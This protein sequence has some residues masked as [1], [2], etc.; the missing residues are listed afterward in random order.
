MQSFKQLVMHPLRFRLFLFTQL[1]SAWFAGVRI[2]HIDE[3]SAIVTVK[4][5]W[6]NKNP[7]HSMYF[8][9]LSIAGEISTGIL[10]MAMI[11]KNNPP[12][13]MLI[14]KNEAQFFKKATGTIR[15][16]CKA[17]E[18][19][20][21]TVATAISTGEGQTITCLSEAHNE[22]GE[23]VASFLFTWSFKAKQPRQS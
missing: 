1:P 17:G 5:Q 2:V 6:F 19:I 12:V 22:A 13:S 9:I 16:T 23:L 7:F 8:G 20:A 10:G 11:Y 15:F 4:Q 3:K 21:Q 18:A 14:V